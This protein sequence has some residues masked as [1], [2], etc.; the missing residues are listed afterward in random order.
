MRCEY[1]AAEIDTVFPRGVCIRDQQFSHR[2]KTSAALRIDRASV[3]NYSRCLDSR[4][5]TKHL[6]L[7]SGE[8]PGPSVCDKAA[9]V[10]WHSGLHCVDS[11]VMLDAIA[12]RQTRVFACGYVNVVGVCFGVAGR[13]QVAARCAHRLRFSAATSISLRTEQTSHGLPLLRSC[14]SCK[15]SSAS[16]GYQTKHERRGRCGTTARAMILQQLSI[17]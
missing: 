7:I 6:R 1:E 2:L 13:F 8:H 16:Q 5:T 17:L 14:E 11:S 9:P 10:A 15:L 4:A 3:D 12:R